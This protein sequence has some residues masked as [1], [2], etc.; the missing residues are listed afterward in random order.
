[1]FVFRL[2]KLEGRA[3]FLVVSRPI[4][5]PDA[6]VDG[7]E[8]AGFGT[9]ESSGRQWM[10]AL[11]GATLSEIAS[12]DG[13]LQ[14]SVPSCPCP[15]GAPQQPPEEHDHGHDT[16]STD[17]SDQS[18]DSTY[19]PSTDSGQHS[20]NSEVCLMLRAFSDTT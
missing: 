4:F 9:D 8:A 10:P 15:E 7:G 14:F 13:Q 12:F 18:S 1:M 16:E 3:P 19:H 11:V 6:R 5:V 17:H 2:V 20:D